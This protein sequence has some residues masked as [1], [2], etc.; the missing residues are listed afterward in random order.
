MSCGF[1]GLNTLSHS[2]HDRNLEASECI[3][4]PHLRRKNEFL[5]QLFKQ[6]EQTGASLLMVSHN[7][8]I[9]KRFDRL[10]EIEKIS[11]ISV[12]KEKIK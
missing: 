4:N 10:I 11:D 9:A 2:L 7:T 1:S 5:N 3:A 8:H 6:K 12:E